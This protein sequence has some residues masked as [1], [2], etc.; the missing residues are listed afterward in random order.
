MEGVPGGGGQRRR[1]RRGGGPHGAQA[2]GQGWQRDRKAAARRK[3]GRTLVWHAV[4]CRGQKF[5]QCTCCVT[6]KSIQVRVFSKTHHGT[7]F[8]ASPLDWTGTKAHDSNLA[9]TRPRACADE[10]EGEAGGDPGPQ[11][12]QQEEVRD[13][14]VRPGRLRHQAVRRGQALREEVCGRRGGHED[15]DGERADRCPGGRT[16][17]APRSRQPNSCVGT[18]ERMSHDAHAV[19]RRW[20]C[21]GWT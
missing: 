7:A 5:G 12:A 6:A 20:V 2:A 18:E 13:D 1:R 8:A 11:H 19:N 21:C 3:G 10:E 15:A 14:G 16:F 9:L 17:E 4:L